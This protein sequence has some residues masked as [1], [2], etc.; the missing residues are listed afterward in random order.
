MQRPALTFAL[1]YHDA[2]LASWFGGL[3]HYL[4]CSTV[5]LNLNK[6]FNLIFIRFALRFVD[7]FRIFLS[8]LFLL[9]F[10]DEGSW[11]HLWAK[12]AFNLVSCIGIGWIRC[13]FPFSIF[14]FPN[15]LSI[16]IVHLVAKS[17]TIFGPLA[18]LVGT[19]VPEQPLAI[20][21]PRRWAMW[22]AWEQRGLLH[23]G[24]GRAVWLWGT[25]KVGCGWA[26]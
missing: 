19:C 16:F 23:K 2:R 18:A 9:C 10:F 12:V 11:Q 15:M 13:H 25:Y 5:R 14:H 20:I 26:W 22:A 3:Q 6:M 4:E 8:L 21:T 7:T 24:R 1:D 17:R